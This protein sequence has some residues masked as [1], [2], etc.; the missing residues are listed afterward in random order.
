M[1]LA[2]Q[3][4]HYIEQCMFHDVCIAWGEHALVMQHITGQSEDPPD[5][6]LWEAADVTF[7]M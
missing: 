4:E 1:T 2:V 7:E 5:L 6:P 3:K